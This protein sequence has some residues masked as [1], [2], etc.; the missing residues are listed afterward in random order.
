MIQRIQTLFL[1]LAAACGIAAIFVPIMSFTTT[2]GDFS[3]SCLGLKLSDGLT[4]DTAEYLWILTVI[5]VIIPIISLLT[6]F[7]FKHRTVQIRISIFNM[8]LM[9]GYYAIFFLNYY[10]LS[11]KY[12]VSPTFNWPIILPVVSLILTWL[13]IRSIAKD[14]ALV[15][16]YNRLR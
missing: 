11:L 15:Q 7:F 14:E 6:I 8:L 5:S 4:T 10:Y 3:L 12:E 2:A 1:L 9:L 13:A 16:S